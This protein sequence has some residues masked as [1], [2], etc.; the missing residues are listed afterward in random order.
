MCSV[1]RAATAA[2]PRA[3]VSFIRND[4][5]VA[6]R[7]S[8][9]VVVGF[10]CFVLQ[11]HL[12][13]QSVSL[14]FACRSTKK[15]HFDF[16]PALLLLRHSP[17]GE[18]IPRLFTRL[19]HFSAIESKVTVS[20]FLFFLYPEAVALVRTKTWVVNSTIFWF[21]GVDRRL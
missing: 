1:T 21:Y 20:C 8:V 19:R 14:K 6:V 18:N 13:V 11:F 15:T 4:G 9:C 16:G 12:F 3:L 7:F 17:R 10:F 5:V 2:A